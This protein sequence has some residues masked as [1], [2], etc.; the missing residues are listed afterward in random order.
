MQLTKIVVT[1]AMAAMAAA[2]VAPLH[3]RQTGGEQSLPSERKLTPSHSWT[4]TNVPK[5][6]ILAVRQAVSSLCRM[7]VSPH[8]Y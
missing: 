1:I 6:T 4:H 5:P 8:P 7:S 3:I 2:L